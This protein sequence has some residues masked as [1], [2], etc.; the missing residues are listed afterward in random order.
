[1]KRFTA[2]GLG[3]FALNACGTNDGNTDGASGTNGAGATGGSGNTGGTGAAG[4]NGGGAGSTGGA[5]TNGSAGTAAGSTSAGGMAGSATTPDKDVPTDQSAEA[6]S[7]FLDALDYRSATWASSTT[8]PFT[9]D[10]MLLSPHG[11]VQIW[12][13]QTMR[14]SRATGAMLG[15]DFATNSMVVKEMYTGST[16][17]GHAAMWKADGS[18]L[19]YCTATEP[20]RCTMG[21]PG[22][23]LLYPATLSNCGCHGAGTIISVK[24][25]PAP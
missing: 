25:I 20:D 9:S 19:Y 14:T 1:M 18:W 11:L 3:L 2:L 5:G 12:Y 16:V 10:P 4:M 24:E 15:G 23:V 17:V 6:I 13:N 21:D 7:A 22:N 8:A